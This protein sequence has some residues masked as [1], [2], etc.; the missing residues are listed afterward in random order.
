MTGDG[1]SRHPEPRVTL[2]ECLQNRRG[3]LI[4]L[5]ARSPSRLRIAAVIAVALAAGFVAWLL[6]RDSGQSPTPSDAEASPPATFAIT[7]Q[8]LERLATSIRQPIFWL[9]RKAGYTYELTKG[10]AGKIYVRYLPAGIAVGSAKPYLTVATYPFP[11]AYAALEKQAAAK[12]AVTAKLAGGGIAVLDSSY[13]ESVHVAYP[14]VPFQ[15]EVYDPT[16]ARAM[17]LVSG[18]EVASLGQLALRRGTARPER[19]SA[20][21]GITWRA[22]GARRPSRSP[23]LLGGAESRATPT[24]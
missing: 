22:Q 8:N 24:S 10:Q 23:D 1:R 21:R 9:G 12:G 2:P 11:G 19:H 16:P 14:N 20:G 7:P 4:S 15:V 13:P 6:L 17:Q 5:R 18:G 3:R